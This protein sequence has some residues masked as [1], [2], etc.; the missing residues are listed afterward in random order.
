MKYLFCITLN[1]KMLLKRT[2]VGTT[3]MSKQLTIKHYTRTIASYNFHKRNSL[4]HKKKYNLA[5]FYGLVKLLV[6]IYLGQSYKYI[7]YI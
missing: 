4:L 5:C 3:Y 1:Y 7:Y 2:F 6:H